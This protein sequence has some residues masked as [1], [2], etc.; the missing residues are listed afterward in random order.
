MVQ[1]SNSITH[2]KFRIWLRPDGIVQ[3]VWF[4]RTLV[5]LADANAAVEGLAKI[6][7]GKPRA[8]LVDMRDTGAQDRATRAAWTS[9]SDLQLATALI[10][11]TPLSRVMGN[12]FINM[13]RPRIPT[14]LFHNEA[15]A[16]RWLLKFV[17]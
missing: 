9:R 5:A 7:G 15:S 17:H 8:L 13:S 11:G 2:A 10:V 1:D 4:P 6:G 14:R 3:I 12:V 16:V